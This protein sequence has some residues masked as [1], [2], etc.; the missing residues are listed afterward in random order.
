MLDVV[1]K[2][3]KRL[4]YVCLRNFSIKVN[5]AMETCIEGVRVMNLAK[6]HVFS[7]IYTFFLFGTKFVRTPL[8]QMIRDTKSPYFVL[9][10]MSLHHRSFSK[11]YFSYLR[12]DR[13]SELC[14]KIYLQPEFDSRILEIEY[15][16]RLLLNPK[17]CSNNIDRIPT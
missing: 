6:L 13:I 11:L 7:R 5:V 3:G 1:K 17:S 15:F 8:L 10:C 12:N 2:F 14:P 4:V 9:S 16:S